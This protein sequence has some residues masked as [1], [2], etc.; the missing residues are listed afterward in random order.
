[1][2]P[3]PVIKVMSLDSKCIPHYLLCDNRVVPC[4]YFSL[5]NGTM[6][7]FVSR[8]R[9]RD[10]GEGKGLYSWLWC[11]LPGGSYSVCTVCSSGLPQYTEPAATDCFLWSIAAW[12]LLVND[13]LSTFQA[14]L[15]RVL[16]AELSHGW[17]PQELQKAVSQ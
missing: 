1:M 3:V 2:S 5:V 8:R 13:F 11:T 15:Q 7:C 12:H 4:N 6:L 14:A 17:F 16:R 10:A 9:K